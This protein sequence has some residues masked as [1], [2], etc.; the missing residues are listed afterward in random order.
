MKTPI[1]LNASE[2]EVIRAIRKKGK[3]A[4]NDVSEITGWSKAK[5]SQEVNSLI[6]KGYIIDLEEGYSSGGRKPRLLQFNQTLGYIIGVDIGATSL[7]I[8]LAGIDGSILERTTELSDV[9][10]SPEIIFQEITVHLIVLSC[11]QEYCH[12]YRPKQY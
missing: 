9:R 7:D 4:R 3:V 8:A 5:T 1:L 12:Q 6:A 2:A 10:L 11:V